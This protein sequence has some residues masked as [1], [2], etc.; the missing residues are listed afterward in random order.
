MS[1]YL[2]TA[3]GVVVSLV[4]FLLTYRQTIGARRERA[5]AARDELMRVVLKRVLLEGFNP[6]PAELTDLTQAKA[7]ERN[8]HVSDLL[9]P[10]ELLVDVQGAV[11]GNDFISEDIRTVV[12]GRLRAAAS[13]AREA[14]LAT[15]QDPASTAP[16]QQN[17]GQQR[18][19]AVAAALIS[20]VGALVSIV[21]G[22]S[23]TVGDFFVG[24]GISALAVTAAG[25]GLRLRET[26]EDEPS[27]PAAVMRALRFERDVAHALGGVPG[28]NVRELP[29]PVDFELRHDKRLYA[30][31]A[32][33]WT[34]RTR[35]ATAEPALQ[36]LRR[37][38]ESIGADELVVVVK[39]VPEW[40][41]ERDADGTHFLNLAQ[42]NDWFA[43]SFASEPRQDPSPGNYL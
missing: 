37:G 30:V 23:H 6:T 11:F 38:A 7:R 2:Q 9:S 5:R 35:R 3:I 41:L 33:L 16:S 40:V 26:Q 17:Q 42:L 1:A 36:R 39:E 19:L 43:R 32:K 20:I 34:K 25:L 27:P 14:E 8:V 24:L 4:L 31:E 15:D 13:Q 21:P 28:A 22:S 10:T 18:L 12:L 29:G